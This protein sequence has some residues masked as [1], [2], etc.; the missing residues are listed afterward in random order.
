[1]NIPTESLVLLAATPIGE[2][3]DAPPRLL[4]ALQEADVVAAED[5]RR[6]LAL[7][8]RLGIRIGG[9]IVSLH[10]HNESARAAEVVEAADGG[11]FV[12]VV[13]DAGMPSVSDPGYRVARAAID[14]GVRVSVLP[15]PS[16]ALT[17]LAVSGLPTDRFTFEGFLPRRDGDRDRALD[18]LAHD[19]RTMI[20]FESPR[21]VGVTLAAMARAFGGNR[22][23]AVCR[24]LTKTHEEV[25]RGSLTELAAATADGVL[26]EVTVVVAGADEG[27]RAD[28]AA[29]TAEVGALVDLGV[30]LKDAAAHVAART[31]LGTRELYQRALEARE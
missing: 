30:R 12:V 6:L 18:A 5:T 26:G 3:T 22:P 9:R 1:M 28:V 2:T 14:A 21:R 16:A 7:A 24:E 4:T 19:P 17:A 25:L 29:A 27:E 23:A 8:K 31:G 10:E 13:T 20:F 11:A 15:G